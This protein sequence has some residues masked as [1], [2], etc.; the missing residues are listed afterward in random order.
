MYDIVWYDIVTNTKH[1]MYWNSTRK[2]I[3]YCL[4][5]DSK[6][7]GIPKILKNFSDCMGN[8][9]LESK[10]MEIIR[11]L[12]KSNKLAVEYDKDIGYYGL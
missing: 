10:Y 1:N 6:K 12:E 9:V 3:V 8:L 2:E 11:E 7:F 5:L 4:Q